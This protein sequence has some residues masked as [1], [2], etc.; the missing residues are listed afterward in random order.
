MSVS[1][2]PPSSS[3]V[4][5]GGWTPV[6]CMPKSRGLRRQLNVDLLRLV[7]LRDADVEDLVLARAVAVHRDAF[8]VQVEREQVRLLHVLDGGLTWQIDRLRD[9]G[10]APVL[11]GGLHSHVPF[12]RDVM[13]RRENSLPFLRDLL[14]APWRAVV[15]EDLFDKIVTPESLALRDFFKVVEEIRQPFPVHHALVP[16]QAGLGLAAPGRIRDH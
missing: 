8:A 11:E 13:G 15:V 3:Y 16:D 10:V 1:T 6:L 7:R 14:Q 12:R 2:A 9:R 4:S 5:P